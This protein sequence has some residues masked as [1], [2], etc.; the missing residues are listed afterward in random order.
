[1]INQIINTPSGLNCCFQLQL[2]LNIPSKGGHDYGK[3]KFREY[4]NPEGVAM[5]ILS[6]AQQP[7]PAV[8]RK[9]QSTQVRA[10]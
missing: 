2:W 6:N 7:Q 9:R 3:W 10:R 5:I 1:M 4:I 8:P